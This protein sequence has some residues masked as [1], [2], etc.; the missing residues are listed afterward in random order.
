MFLRLLLISLILLNACGYDQ[1]SSHLAVVSDANPANP[2]NKTTDEQL[3]DGLMQLI[4]QANEQPRYGGAPMYSEKLKNK[5]FNDLFFP[6]SKQYVDITALTSGKDAIKS[7]NLGTILGKMKTATLNKELPLTLKWTDKLDQEHEL[8]FKVLRVKTKSG[9]IEMQLILT[10]LYITCKGLTPNLNRKSLQN[11]LH[12]KRTEYGSYTVWVAAL[13][14]PQGG[15][16][17]F[18]QPDLSSR[19]LGQYEAATQAV[20]PSQ[21]AGVKPEGEINPQ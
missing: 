2:F 7:S 20:H 13:E 8:S 18:F 21:V 16:T 17:F 11:P 5:G 4:T 15:Y 10:Q 6:A 1:Q 12:K 3:V 14:I 9:A 19:A